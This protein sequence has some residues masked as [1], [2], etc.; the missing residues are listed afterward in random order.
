MPE[1]LPKGWSHET[2]TTGH[3]THDV[4]LYPL[5]GGLH[6]IRVIRTKQTDAYLYD[7]AYGHLTNKKTWW[8]SMHRKIFTKTLDFPLE[9][10]LYAATVIHRKWAE[11]KVTDAGYISDC[12]RDA[13]QEQA[14]NILH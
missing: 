12:I 3:D 10:A 8:K 9:N 2:F 5:P 11:Q 7:S 6:A 1:K 13:M 4:Y 14:Q